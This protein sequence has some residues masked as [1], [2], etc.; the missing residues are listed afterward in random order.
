VGEPGRGST[1]EERD[2]AADVEAGLGIY[3]SGI[4]GMRADLG[5]AVGSKEAYGKAIEHHRRAVQIRPDCVRAIAELLQLLYAE[6][7]EA[8]E[9]E[10]AELG[11]RLEQ[12]KSEEDVKGP[13]RRS[14]F[15]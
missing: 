3:W 6:S 14:T 12:Q 8:A 4:A 10:R 15:C 7:G 13:A 1:Q 9:A 2:D 5:D 11:R